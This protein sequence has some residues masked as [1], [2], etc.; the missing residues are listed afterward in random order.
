MCNIIHLNPYILITRNYL[1]LPLSCDSN[2]KF[3][4]Q[5]NKKKADKLLTA[6]GF[7][8]KHPPSIFYFVPTVPQRSTPTLKKTST[9]MKRL[10]WLK[11]ELMPLQCKK[12]C[13]RHKQGQ[14]G[15]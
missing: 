10:S 9:R 5:I 8:R 3:S 12:G 6:S 13:I 11:K 15:I 1:E 7:Y 2:G 4:I 14:G